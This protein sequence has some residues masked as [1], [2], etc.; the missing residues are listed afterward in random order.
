MNFKSDENRKYFN[1]FNTVQDTKVLFNQELSYLGEINRTY[2]A[3]QNKKAK[4]VLLFNLQNIQKI[5]SVNV[6]KSSDDLENLKT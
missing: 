6:T 2:K 1:L 3:A 5:T 4:E